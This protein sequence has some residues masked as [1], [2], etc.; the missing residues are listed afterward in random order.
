MSCLSLFLESILTMQY[1]LDRVIGKATYSTLI[2][3]IMD[4]HV[5]MGGGCP[6]L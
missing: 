5:R 1:F 6:Q 2:I 4:D 3:F